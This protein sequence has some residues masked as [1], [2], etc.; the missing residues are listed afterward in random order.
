MKDK[1]LMIRDFLTKFF[2]KGK[3]ADRS[4]LDFPQQLLPMSASEFSFPKQMFLPLV[5]FSAC[6]ENKEY[7][8]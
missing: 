7:D 5:A 2:A 6:W 1:R 8:L 3:P 4:G